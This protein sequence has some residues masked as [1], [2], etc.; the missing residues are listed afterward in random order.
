MKNIF[1]KHLLFIISLI[2]YN[3]HAQTFREFEE[4]FLTK[5]EFLIDPSSDFTEL[6]PVLSKSCG[7]EIPDLSFSWSNSFDIALAN[8]YLIRKAEEKAYKEWYNRQLN[9]VIKPAI[10][11]KLGQKFSSYGD[12]KKAIF[13]HSENENIRINLPRVKNKFEGK[14]AMSG[15]NQKTSL[16]KLKLLKTREIELNSGNI[17]SSKFAYF[18]INDTY[19]KDIKTIAD[20][21]TFW[22]SEEELFKSR[23][24]TFLYNKAIYNRL[25]TLGY[26]ILTESLKEKN[27][28]YDNFQYWDRLDLMQ[29][30]INFELFKQYSMPPYAL[31]PQ[32]EKFKGIDIA[33]EDFIEDY[34]KKHTVVSSLLSPNY[35]AEQRIIFTSNNPSSFGRMSAGEFFDSNIA[36]KI[37]IEIQEALNKLLNETPIGANFSVDFIVE[38]FHISDKYQLIWLN[39]NPN[40]ATEIKNLLGP[41]P[42]N[43]DPTF[44]SSVLPQ[45]QNGAKLAKF[46]EDADITGY[47]N[48]RFIYDSNSLTIKDLMNFANE[49]RVNGVISN[50]VKELI[51]QVLKILTNETE[52]LKE[53]NSFMLDLNLYQETAITYTSLID[54]F[55]NIKNSHFDSS[56]DKPLFSN[57]CAINLSHALLKSGVTINSSRSVITCYGCNDKNYKNRH[58]IRAQELANWLKISKINGLGNLKELNGSNFK[59]Y[60]SGKKGIIFFKDYWQRSSDTGNNRTGD[61]IDIWTGNG[62]ASESF[63]TDFFRLNFPDITE[64]IFGVSSLYQSKVVYFWELND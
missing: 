26:E 21:K 45:L 64:S 55:E 24:I 27:N 46:I 15:A 62:L 52:E 20:L 5:D 9:E 7:C 56:G 51:N 11:N 18:K 23:H 41:N 1:L 54:N 17:N 37:K 53:L 43:T 60:V 44:I 16:K 63:F 10:E 36:P 47:Y 32:F 39:S 28:F 38:K 57:Y 50:D 3:L 30:L 14:T 49:N 8:E 25:P 19:I 29:V 35:L 61:H 59:Q 58:I 31:S 2:S 6:K 48:I 22:S 13:E 12:A 34:A 40:K 4:D 42:S 33:N